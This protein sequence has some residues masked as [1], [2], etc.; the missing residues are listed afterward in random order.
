M[1]HSELA[2]Q[3]HIFRKSRLDLFA[4]GRDNLLEVVNYNMEGI[5]IGSMDS[6]AQVCSMQNTFVEVALC[7]HAVTTLKSKNILLIEL[8]DFFF[9]D[10]KLEADLHDINEVTE[11]PVVFQV[12]KLILKQEWCQMHEPKA[13]SFGCKAASISCNVNPLYFPIHN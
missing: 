5:V 3:R 13:P 12:R 11:V 1:C 7:S 9:S 2:P 6:L 4:I 10:F 8:V